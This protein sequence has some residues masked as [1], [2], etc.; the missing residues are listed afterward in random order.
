M[1][2]IENNDIR[3]RAAGNLAFLLSVIRCGEVLSPDEEA[4]VRKV[5]E[6]LE[7]HSVPV[8]GSWAW[9]LD[10]MKA[11][12][13]V[14]NPDFWENWSIGFKGSFLI[15]Y[16]DRQPSAKS[17]DVD[18]DWFDRTDWQIVDTLPTSREGEG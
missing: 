14:D 9:A 6:E 3:H 8:Q 1:T 16:I 11:G 18:R 17:V 12:K 15:H 5:I 7:A 4:N 10:R 13:R 2:P